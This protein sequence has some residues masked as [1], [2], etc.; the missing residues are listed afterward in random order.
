[1]DERKAQLKQ[2]KKISNQAKRLYS[3]LWKVLSILALCLATAGVLGGGI[4]QYLELTYWPYIFCGAAGML[5][6][7]IVMLIPWSVGKMR[8]KKSEEYLNYRTMKRAIRDE[9]RLG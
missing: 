1:M 4:A 9:R 6:F 5:V 7:G 3:T 8:W 2:L